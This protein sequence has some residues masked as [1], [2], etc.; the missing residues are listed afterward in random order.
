MPSDTQRALTNVA[1]DVTN[2]KEQRKFQYKENRY[3]IS[4]G[5]WLYLAHRLAKEESIQV[6]I[7]LASEQ[8][9]NS[10]THTDL[11]L[12]HLR[13]PNT[14]S[15]Q[16]SWCLNQNTCCPSILVVL[17]YCLFLTLKE[18]SLGV[19][20]LQS[21]EQTT[22]YPHPIILLLTTLRYKRFID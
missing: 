17:N 5:A 7:S 8:E 20:K 6:A 11:S 13:E 12:N 14:P 2:Q 1:S 19:L 3:L 22:L 10:Q 4:C 16:N 15:A 9:I 21:T 18:G